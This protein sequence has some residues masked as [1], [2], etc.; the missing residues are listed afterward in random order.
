MNTEYQELDIFKYYIISVALKYHSIESFFLCLI[1]TTTSVLSRKHT[2]I[3]ALIWFGASSKPLTLNSGPFALVRK[4]PLPSLGTCS[5]NTEAAL[6]RIR[7]ISY[8]Q[9]NSISR[10]SPQ[11]TKWCFANPPQL[12]IAAANITG[13]K[14]LHPRTQICLIK[15]GLGLSVLFTLAY[16]SDINAYG[17]AS[18]LQ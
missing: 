11:Q 5:D 6:I 10:T 1:S 14:W 9:R 7:D 16:G 18:P 2:S 15:H 3:E 8:N 4:A 17:N 12:L 13:H